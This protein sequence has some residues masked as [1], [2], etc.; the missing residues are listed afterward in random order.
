M[1][2]MQ[3]ESDTSNSPSNGESLEQTTESLE[4][5]VD[6]LT[7]EVQTVADEILVEVRE[8]QAKQ[9]RMLADLERLQS[10]GGPARIQQAQEIL[11]EM[12]NAREEQRNLL[13]ELRILLSE[14]SESR[15]STH[16]TPAIQQTNPPSNLEPINPE[17]AEAAGP[18]SKKK[19]RFRI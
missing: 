16:S 15:S 17:N 14:S 9:D 5:Q 7:E 10:E 8:C 12:R 18:K 19:K 6:D 4:T 13:A 3:P 2:P 1:T 11:T